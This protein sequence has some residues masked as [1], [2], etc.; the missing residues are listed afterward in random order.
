MNLTLSFKLPIQA[1][2]AY[3]FASTCLASVESTV[4]PTGQFPADV[5]NVQNAINA[6]GTIHLKA[7]DTNGVAQ[8]FNFGST[9]F[10]FKN[11][12]Q[13][14]TSVFLKGE[15][16]R[17]RTTT[18]H[19]GNL[20]IRAFGTGSFKLDGVR[21]VEPKSIGVLIQGCSHT[22]IM[23]CEI[24]DV[25]GTD[26]GGFTFGAGISARGDSITGQL[27]IHDNSITNVNAEDGYGILV[28]FLAAS[29]SIEQN[30]VKN[31]NL[32][33]ILV[34]GVVSLAKI[35]G[36]TVETGPAQD[37]DFT[38]GNGILCGHFRG[39]LALIADNKVVCENQFADGISLVGGGTAPFPANNSLIVNNEVTMHG[40]LFGG[41]SL[42]DDSSNNRVISNM[43]KGDGAVALQISTYI[44]GDPAD[45][46]SFLGNNISGF[47][48]T[49]ASIFLDT[50]SSRTLVIGHNGKVI[51]LGTNNRIL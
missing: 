22:E 31:V 45:R 10:V 49:Y 26:N 33:G 25:I 11:D 8:E 50:N 46:N 42:Y 40:S 30:K 7:T 16:K 19:G 47:N 41:I 2:A 23:N 17:G 4:Y 35:I 1:A 13:S 39:G 5:I 36:N 18:I 32:N 12:F 28:A 38:A 20:P 29:V 48:Y 44:S 34:G 6:G 24:R 15:T 3:F 21:V 43:I 14:T 37:M 27:M 9:G 51:D